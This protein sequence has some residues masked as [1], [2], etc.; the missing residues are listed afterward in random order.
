MEKARITANFCCNATGTHKL[1][2]W[3]IG[4]AKN[5][6][7]FGSQGVHACNLHMIWRSN[8]RA[9]MSGDIFQ[10]YLRW[11][12][13]N[14]SRKVVLLIDNFSAH[15][16]GWDIIVAEGGLFNVSVIFLSGNA[17]S[18]CQSLDQ[19]IIDAFK[20]HYRQGSLQTT[21]LRVHGLRI[22]RR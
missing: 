19:D 10:E 18:L 5:P 14:V 2:I 22:R 3:F 15:Q 11:F 12:N 17:I 9:W 20:A 1:L 13:G 6:R 8:S 21:L 7:A 16:S 4:T